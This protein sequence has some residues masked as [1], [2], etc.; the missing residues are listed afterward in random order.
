MVCI[1]CYLNVRIKPIHTLNDDSKV[2]TSWF[3]NSKSLSAIIA[4]IVAILFGGL[5]ALQYSLHF[6]QLLK[7]GFGSVIIPAVPFF[8]VVAESLLPSDRSSN[9]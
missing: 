6:Y 2:D 1:S 9:L 8:W 5:T 4:I 3:H 7:E